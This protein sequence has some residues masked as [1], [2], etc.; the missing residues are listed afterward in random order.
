MCNVLQRHP[1]S[2]TERVAQDRRVG[3]TRLGW[4]DHAEL[5]WAK[6][7]LLMGRPAVFCAG[8]SGMRRQDSGVLVQNSLV[9]ARA[10]GVHMPLLAGLSPRACHLAR[11]C[12]PRTLQQQSVPQLTG[13]Q[14]VVR[15]TH[16]VNRE[17]ETAHNA[18]NVTLHPIQQRSACS[19]W[20]PG[21]RL[22]HLG[23]T[24]RVDCQSGEDIGAR[25]LHSAANS[26]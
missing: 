3:N 26:S 23:S 22:Q 12:I 20:S 13:M 16:A 25:H 18:K 24:A 6:A 9:G 15:S 14:L 10:E 4:R 8:S 21:L 7:K 1:C 11:A 19:R 2:R 17:E 5:L